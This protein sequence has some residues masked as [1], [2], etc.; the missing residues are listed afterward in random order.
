M[1]QLEAEVF[2]RQADSGSALTRLARARDLAERREQVQETLIQTAQLYKG[3]R[4]RGPWFDTLAELESLCGDLR[5]PPGPWPFGSTPPDDA[6]SGRPPGPTWTVGLWVRVQRAQQYADE[7]DLSRELEELHAILGEHGNVLLPASTADRRLR[8]DEDESPVVDRIGRRLERRGGRKAYAPFE[9][10]ARELFEVAIAGGDLEA[11]ETIGQLYP[12][13]EAARDSADARLETAFEAGDVDEVARLVQG[14]LPEP[15]N[16]AEASERQVKVLLRLA[17]A[18]GAKDNA[19]FADGLLGALARQ[20]PGLRSDLDAH[21]GRALSELV[22]SERRAPLA[23]VSERSTFDM[24]LVP[25]PGPAGQLLVAGRGPARPG[26]DGRGGLGSHA[27]LHPAR[28]PPGRRSTPPTPASPASGSGPTSSDRSPLL[29]LTPGRCQFTPLRVLVATRSKLVA[30]DSR[31]GDVRWSWPSGRETIDRLEG[32]SGVVL[33]STSQARQR[34]LLALDATSGVELWKRSIPKELK[35]AP[36]TGPEHAVL[37][38][39]SRSHTQADVLD[40]FT[41]RLARTLDLTEVAPIHDSDQRGAWVEERRLVLPLFP[42]S[43]SKQPRPCVVAYDLDSGRRAWRVTRDAD[44]ELDSIARVGND[45]YLLFLGTG[46]PRSSGVLQQLDTR[47]GAVRPIQNVRLGPDDVPIG[48][49]RSTRVELDGPYLFLLS[50]TSGGRETL[51][52]AIHLPFG[53]R[54][55]HRLPLSPEEFYNTP[56]PLPALSNTTVA[57]AYTEAPR[58]EM[59]SRAQARTTLLLLDRKSGFRRDSRLLDDDLG[60]AQGLA[61]AALGSALLVQGRDQLLVLAKE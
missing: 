6:P 41:G 61:L 27:D 37:L 25:V 40:L 56:M 21:A 2:V 52:R 57:L 50:P 39:A 38:P 54:W 43:S 28:A 3:R 12:H 31:T 29:P 44:Q 4:E 5:M 49:R 18:L 19:A 45:V 48:I 23:P 16:P 59:R 1:A 10:R 13:S 15:W 30:L 17:L 34:W 58:S 14:E 46:G 32:A 20:H 36:V 7:D 51:I 8:L 26:R 11:L 9:K 47:L 24:D 42:K 53:E 35:H 22:S 55:T 60:Q 33:I